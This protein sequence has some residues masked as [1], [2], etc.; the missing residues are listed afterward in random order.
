VNAWQ[1]LI[2][3]LPTFGKASSVRGESASV[4]MLNTHG[5]EGW[6]AVGMAT[7]ADGSVAVLLKRPSRPDHEA[8][9]GRPSRPG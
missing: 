1:Y 8:S 4:E 7:L 2:V 9:R 5:S 3:A 6:E